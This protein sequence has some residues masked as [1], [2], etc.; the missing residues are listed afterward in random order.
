MVSL[1][2]IWCVGGPFGGVTFASLDEGLTN[3]PVLSFD[4]AVHMGVV[5]GDADVA[6]II[7]VCK[8]VE[9]SNIGHAIVS[10]NFFDGAP[11]AQDILKKK[12]AEGATSFCA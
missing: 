4:N 11:P 9:G 3:S 12:C 5:W 10:D 2:N 8:P 7:P 1:E 6:N